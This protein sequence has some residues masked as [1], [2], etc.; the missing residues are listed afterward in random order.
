M[1][2]S[3]TIE[4]FETYPYSI[5]V[6]S[7][8]PRG[9]SFFSYLLGLLLPRDYDTKRL[10]LLREGENKLIDVEFDDC[11]YEILTEDATTQSPLNA[12]CLRKAACGVDS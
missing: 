3:I 7:R 10:L 9:K 5:P 4:C 11:Y 6:Q 2:K 12:R 1:P 8:Y